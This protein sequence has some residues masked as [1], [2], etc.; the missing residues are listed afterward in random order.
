V[1]AK[2]FAAA[3]TH[4]FTV[5]NGLPENTVRCVYVDRE[6]NLWIG[7]RDK[8]LAK[9]SS[10]N[11]MRFPLGYL[12]YWHHHRFAVADSLSHLWIVSD[13]DLLEVWRD[14]FQLWHSAP[15]GLYHGPVPLPEFAN[16]AIGAV[17]LDS[18]G[19]LWLT[20][21]GTHSV[22]EGYEIVRGVD[23]KGSDDQPAVLKKFSTIALGNRLPGAGLHPIIAARTGEIWTGAHGLARLDP[24][25]HDPVVRIYTAADGV[26]E[27]YIRELYE[28]RNGNVWVGTLSDGALRI[29]P[30]GAM[31]RFTS[32]EGLADN[33]VWAFCEDQAGRMLIG[34]SNG[35]LATLDGDSITVLTQREGLPTNKIF[36]ATLDSLGRLWLG[37]SIGII[38]EDH[39][40]SRTFIKNQAFLGSGV[41]AAGTTRNGLVWFITAT[42]LWVYDYTHDRAD[43]IRPPVYLTRLVVNGLDRVIAPTMELS[44][45]ETNYELAFV[46]IS[47]KDEGAVRYR[48]R[49]LGADGTWHGPTYAHS[50][51]YGNLDPGLYRFE[52]K[53]MNI[54]GAESTAPATMAFTISRPYWATWPFRAVAIV[55]MLSATLLAYVR[56]VSSLNAAR[57]SQQEFSRQLIASQEEERNR[58]AGELHDDLGQ[59][60]MVIINRAHLGLKA[61]SLESAKGQ[62]AQIVETSA[63]SIEKVRE[64]AFN[65]SPQ[66]LQQLGLS[67]SLRMMVHKIAAV[68]GIV[69]A[70]HADPIDQ[71]LPRD[72]ELNVYRI[73]QECVNNVGKHSSASHAEVAVHRRE[74]MIEIIVSDDGKGFDVSHAATLSAAQR[75]FGLAGLSERAKLLGGTMAI[76][77]IPGKGTTIVITIPIPTPGIH[78][79]P[80]GATRDH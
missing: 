75:G 79:P 10:G 45:D 39:P 6:Q 80:E 58:V 66:Y 54:D 19:R 53:A 69:F 18:R 60:L 57:L 13:H 43:A 2:S 47:F 27:N 26:P 76:E 9:L 40:G 5:A 8:G 62:L 36:C 41:H 33:G 28:D 56:R 74:C 29:S 48:Y 63:H 14:R 71:L 30:G 44:H 23:S 11:A 15:H 22:V 34:T 51:T 70:F 12:W 31:R 20:K 25:K 46:G 21:P 42:D 72:H 52:V 49:L 37:T 78:P 32:A 7:G 67:E 24:E 1:P 64:I 16:G 73:V 61:G 77:S 3:P 65:L 38:Y 50:V 35:G 17:T 68:P 4:N 59:E 55:V